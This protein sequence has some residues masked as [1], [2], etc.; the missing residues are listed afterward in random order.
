MALRDF[1]HIFETMK[2]N[3]I[4]MFLPRFKDLLRD[5]RMHAIHDA[6]KWKHEISE[7]SRKVGK[8][9]T[10]ENFD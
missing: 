4:S 8:D 9:L 3:K 1:L 7:M 5:C 6:P 10:N 2:K